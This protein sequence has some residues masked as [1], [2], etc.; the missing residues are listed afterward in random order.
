MSRMART[1]FPD[2]LRELPEVAARE[3]YNY[4]VVGRG[5]P[6]VFYKEYEEKARQRHRRFRPRGQGRYASAP[7]VALSVGELV[8]FLAAAAGMGILQ[9]ASYDL[10]KW[11]VRKLRKPKQ[12]MVGRTTRFESVISRETYNRVRRENHPGKKALKTSTTELEQRLE[13]KYRLM[14]TVVD[15]RGRPKSIRRS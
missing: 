15:E 13:T 7:H 12:E 11:L 9:N 5:F 4:R 6:R 10:V 3:I 2:D 1:D 8:L 14:V